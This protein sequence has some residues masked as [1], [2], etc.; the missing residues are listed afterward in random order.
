[1]ASRGFSSFSYEKSLVRGVLA[2]CT[3]VTLQFTKSNWARRLGTYGPGNRPTW[4]CLTVNL[5][6]DTAASGMNSLRQR[7]WFPLRIRA[8]SH[9]RAFHWAGWS[10]PSNRGH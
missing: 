7:P 10:A 4:R 3:T 9:P 5:T 8:K 2:F 1:M 6:V